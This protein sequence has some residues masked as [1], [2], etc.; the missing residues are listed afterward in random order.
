MQ[1][2]EECERERIG[3]LTHVVSPVGLMMRAMSTRCTTTMLE[4]NAN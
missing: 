4:C 2:D 1:R 3:A